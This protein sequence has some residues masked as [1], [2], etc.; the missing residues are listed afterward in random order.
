MAGLHEVIGVNGSLNLSFVCLVGRV[1]HRFEGATGLEAVAVQAVA[2]A[3]QVVNALSDGKAVVQEI[4]VPD[5]R[6]PE[7]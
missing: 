1:R 4:A 2:K 7:D 6:R 3:N 5:V